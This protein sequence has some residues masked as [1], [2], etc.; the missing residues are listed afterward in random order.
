MTVLSTQTNNYADGKISDLDSTNNQYLI[1][2]SDPSNSTNSA[3]CGASFASD[4][5][6]PSNSQDTSDS[7]YI[8]CKV[9]TG[10]V[11]DATTCTSATFN[12]AAGQ[13]C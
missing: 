2:L 1:G 8:N 11:G 5:W 12:D 6:V 10:K 3:N 9:S 4:S 7:N 13:D